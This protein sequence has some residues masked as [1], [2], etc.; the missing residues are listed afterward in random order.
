[1]KEPL[2][3]EAVRILD[4]RAHICVEMANE[5]ALLVM[6]LGEPFDEDT[7]EWFT[8]TVNELREIQAILESRDMAEYRAYRERW[9]LAQACAEVEAQLEDQLIEALETEF[10]WKGE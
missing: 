1:M 5:C 10:N 8:E 7:R 4:E 6:D 3:I 9:E 2:T